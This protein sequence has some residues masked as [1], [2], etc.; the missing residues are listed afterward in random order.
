MW[1]IVAGIPTFFPQ[2]VQQRICT[3][4][5]KV[6][7]HFEGNLKHLVSAWKKILLY[8]WPGYTTKLSKQDFPHPVT[9]MQNG[10][11]II[12]FAL[13]DLSL[14]IRNF[15]GPSAKKKK[16]YTIDC[17]FIV[18]TSSVYLVASKKKWDITIL[19]INESAVFYDYQC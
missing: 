2:C 7:R 17:V 16:T 12:L 18:E 15:V 19:A 6:T 11:R 3:L 9:L 5:C 13:F 4:D 1:R 10:K 14:A 8:D